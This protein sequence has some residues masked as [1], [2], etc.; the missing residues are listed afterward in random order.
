VTDR[1]GLTTTLLEDWDA[2][3]RLASFPFLLK[4]GTRYLLAAV[5]L[6]LAPAATTQAQGPAP[7][8]WLSWHTAETKHFVFHYSS[9]YREWTLS[10]AERMEALRGEVAAVVGYAPTKR[11]HVVIDDP[12]NDPNGYAFTPLDAPSIVLW[13]VSPDPRSEIGD[14]GV[15]QEMLATHEFTHIAHLTRPSRNRWQ[16]LLRK[17]SPVPLGPIATKAPRAMR[18]WAVRT[19]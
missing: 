13:P 1:I 4:R 2:R 15:W 19:R 16:A 14:Y 11:G 18:D 17:L 10:L 8:P 5:L 9:D 6:S 7:R 3:S 12:V